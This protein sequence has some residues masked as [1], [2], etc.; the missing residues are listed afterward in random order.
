MRLAHNIMEQ[1]FDAPKIHDGLLQFGYVANLRN[2]AYIKE[3]VSMLSGTSSEPTAQDIREIANN[4][5]ILELNINGYDSTSKGEK[6]SPSRVFFKA[7]NTG[8]KNVSNEDIYGWF[9][10]DKDSGTFKGV[11]WGT[12]AQLRAYGKIKKTMVMSFRMGDFYF[13]NIDECL[14]FLDDIAQNTIPESWK[15]KNKPSDLNYPIL[16]S[17]I[18]TIFAKLKNE[19]KV[20][21]SEDGKYI[22]FNTNL[23]DKF[24]HEL[25]IIA[26]VKQAEGL[27]VY[28]HPIRTAEESYSTLR[29]YGFENRRP[30]PPV[31]FKDVNEVIFNT[32]KEWMIDKDYDS[33][34]HII[35]ERISRFPHHWQEKSPDILARKLYDAIKYAL[36]IAQRNYKY[37]VPI[38][39]PRFD[40]IAFLMPI[41]LEGAYSA[42]PDFALVLQTDKEHKLY[43]AKTILDLE[44][45]Y[46]DARI[47]AKPDESW[48]NPVTL[49]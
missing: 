11:Y 25:Y 48:L 5:Q 40:S 28:L 41:F 30:E 49:K 23:L 9:E 31:F 16:K 24:F 1:K 37:I 34:S 45:G 33:L 47:I 2:G 26:E 42:S 22:M 14:S 13:D 20:L 19:E 44:M 27:E 3:L 4:A 21:R 15:F 36:A 32:S 43:I 12:L 18:E 7:F 10:K 17:Y 39:Y 6:I 29:K 8:Y 38:Y 35:E 46:Q